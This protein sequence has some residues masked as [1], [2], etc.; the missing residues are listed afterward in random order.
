MASIFRIATE[1]NI[2][3]KHIYLIVILNLNGLDNNHVCSLLNIKI[4]NKELLAPYNQE[5][6]E[7]YDTLYI[8]SFGDILPNPSNQL[9]HYIQTL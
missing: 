2:P 5:K 7:E 6:P 9:D 3:Y 8:Q 4:S 1:L